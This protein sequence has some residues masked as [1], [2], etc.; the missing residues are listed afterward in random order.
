MSDQT[1]EVRSFDSAA[2]AAG[3][4]W[5]G[6]ADDSV[7]SNALIH[8]VRWHSGLSQAEFAEAY[9]IDLE[10]LR[11]LEAGAIRADSALVAY[12]TVIDRA[13]QIVRAAL[14]TC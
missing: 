7:A 5:A 1:P 3:H 9:R 12:L 11:A 6:A 4:G 14:Q 2:A 13:P 8:R 10:R